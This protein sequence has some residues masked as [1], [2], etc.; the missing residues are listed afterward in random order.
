[1]RNQLAEEVLN[2]QMLHLMLTYAET[3]KD[4]AYLSSTIALLQHTSTLI[5]NF[6]DPRPITDLSDVRLKENMAALQWF[7]NWEESVKDRSD[8][9]KCL[10]SHQTR[11]DLTSLI[12]GFDELCHSKLKIAPSSII[13]NRI[14]SD[15]IENIFCQQRGLYNGNNTNPN[16]LT[17]C[18][19]MNV[20]ILG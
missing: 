2:K 4:S 3:L 11:A 10:I 6:R 16:Y 1:M 14:N 19:T 5:A 7:I 8:K 17:Y 13:P 9:N 15:V 20:I 18:R 12:I